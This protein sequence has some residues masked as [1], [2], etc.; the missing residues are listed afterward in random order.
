MKSLLDFEGRSI[1]RRAPGVVGPKIKAF[2]I[3]VH[4]SVT[5]RQPE[6]DLNREQ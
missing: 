1:R 5:W 3:S 2:E 4:S 6:R